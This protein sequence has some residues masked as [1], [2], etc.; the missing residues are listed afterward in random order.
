MN[1]SYDP[2]L[3]HPSSF[4][5]DMC[6]KPPL[7]L[8]LATIYL[9]RAILLPIGIGIGHFA[10]VDDK[11]FVLLR[12]LWRVEGLVPALLAL[13]VLFALFRRTP[14]A[15]RMT[16]R[17]W[18]HGRIFLAVSAGIDAALSLF[19]LTTSTEGDQPIITMGSELIDVYFLAY[20]LFARRV[21]DTFTDFP[22]PRE[23][24]GE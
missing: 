17:M 1:S 9:A 5:D 13:P 22:P 3:Y 4:D 21:R 8:W 6:L 10:G 7:L 14:T 23:A 18:A 24:A 15:A 2:D 12:S 11:A 16:R 20:I 19:Q